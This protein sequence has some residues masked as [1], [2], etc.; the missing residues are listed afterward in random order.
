MSRAKE[1]TRNTFIITLGRISTQFITFLLLPLYTALLTT[2]EYGIV[3]LVTTMVQ[4]LVPIV[5]IMIDQGVFRYLLNCKSFEEKKRTI[6]SSFFLLVITC[7]FTFLIYLIATLFIEN[8]YF[9]W[10]ILILA[11]TVFSSFFLQIARGLKHTADYA[12]GSFICSLVTILLN[13]LCI[14]GLRMG[15]VGMLIATFVGNVICCVFL[16]CKLKIARYIDF[17]FVEKAIAVNVVKYS[18]PLVPNQ[19][20]LWVM[21]CSDRLI[22]TFFLGA[23]SNGILA[24]S[25][26]FPAIFMTFFNVFLLAWHE[27]GVLHYFDKDRDEFFSEMVG[28]ILSIFSSLCVSVLVVLPLVFNLLVN[29]AYNEAYYNIPV[30]LVAALLNVL[31]GLLG[32]VYVATKKTVEIAKTTIVSAIINVV[33]NVVLIKHIG[34]Y[35]ASLS[36]LTGYFVT[37]IYRIWDTKKYL[38]IKYDTKQI[39]G[40]FVSMISGVILYYLNNKILLLT[41]IPI[42]AIFAYLMNKK[43]IN[44]IFAIVES[45]IGVAQKK[46]EHIIIL[47]L[48]LVSLFCVLII[49]RKVIANPPNIETTYEGEVKSIEPES[50]VFFDDFGAE[51]F[52]CTGLTYDSSS[53]TFWIADCGLDIGGEASEPKL[54]E[55]DVK[56]ERVVNEIFLGDILDSEA[57][58]QGIAYDERDDMLWLAIGAKVIKINK[59]GEI[60]EEIQSVE[61][62]KFSANGICY[63]AIDDTLWILC[64]SKYLFHYQ[65]NGLLIDRYSFHFKAQDHIFTDGTYLYATVGD[66]YLGHENYL[67]QISISTG[68]II[69]L[70]ETKYSNALEGL[71]FLNGNLY[72]LNDGK[73]HE[74]LFGH[75][76]ITVYSENRLN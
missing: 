35:A 73:Y 33:V 67:A 58:L 9:V 47:M 24:V 71:C 49:A 59:F 65:K 56:F 14:A 15:A 34:L 74:D 26:K 18:I 38:N 60:I 3:D 62:S 17:A 27:T 55:V 16:F 23:A 52:T 29:T 1:L 8:K 76:Y 51:D 2:E 28:R 57:N 69:S 13:I 36:T 42:L 11:V 75:S 4:L 10:L 44:D 31:I 72:I 54:V 46:I 61:F 21:N 39:L 37:L 19:L 5:S 7:I 48:I 12:L 6:S 66:D 50:V 64:A 41:A 20:S 63:D 45:K 70:Y 22:V 43:L 68:G 25:H 53:D 40:I 30:Y 32:V